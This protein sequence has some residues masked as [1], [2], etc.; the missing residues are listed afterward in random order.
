MAIPIVAIALAF[1]FL[2]IKLGVD[3]SKAK[4]LAHN[5]SADSSLRVSELEEMIESSV[6]TAVA[7]LI[8]RIDDLESEKLLA[9]SERLLLDDGD[10]SAEQSA[11]R[12]QQIKN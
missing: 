9:T 8:S 6:A 11:V 2:V 12:K 5:V 10:D 7:P 4:M 1:T 3:H